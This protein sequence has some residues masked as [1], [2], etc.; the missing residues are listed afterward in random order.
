[1]PEELREKLREAYNT[2][3]DQRSEEH[4][5]LL[6]AHP[7]VNLTAGVLYQYDE[8]AANELKADQAKIAAKRAEKP[9]EDFVSVLSESP[10]VLPA[11]HVFHRG[12]HRQ[13]KQAV[14]PGDLTIA[15]AEGERFEIED[16]SAELA[17]SGRR[18]AFARHLV[19]GRHP[20]VG[21]VLANRIW[22][23]HF[24]HGIV[25]TPGDF[26]VLG[27]RPSHPELL[28]WL[29]DEL[30]RQGWSLKRVH[31]LIMT[32]T[33]YR[34]SSLR[35]PAAGAIDGDNRLYS[36]F[37]LR[38]LEAE[39][40]RDRIL[41]AGGKLDR[42]LFGPPV[43]V[44]IDPVGQV[45]VKD[46]APRRSIYVEVRRTRPASFLTAFDAPVMSVN[47]ERRVPSTSA[48]QSLMLMNGDFVLKQASLMAE[49]VRA[50]TAG[51]VDNVAESVDSAASAAGS[52][53][54][55]AG[56]GASAAGSVDSAAG[57][58]DSSGGLLA[59]QITRAWSIAYQR[60]PSADELELASQFV[61]G[62]TD[63]LRA[64]GQENP[65]LAALANLCQQ[66]FSSNEFLYVD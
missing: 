33:V 29:A 63:R 19:S 64:A 31:K 58:G 6:A 1:A 27:T 42:T 39:A 28:D 44:E 10:G 40:I 18:L 57:S 65:E 8:A 62:Q 59:R 56:S 15:A 36:R 37:P 45:V 48:P 38:R 7:N 52:V 50:E 35:E 60:G 11:T 25:E 5:A 46:Q 14:R 16:K 20:L 17:T 30:V 61:T 23:H 3:P 66:L 34:Q 32:S 53:A 13:P 4:K 51:S 9:V 24:G 55:A 26:G 41:A 43:P 2:P 22:L 54:S 12:D 47:C 21:R 49:R